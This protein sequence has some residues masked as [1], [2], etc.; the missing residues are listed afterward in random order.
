MYVWQP[1]VPSGIAPAA[2]KMKIWIH[3]ESDIRSG[4]LSMRIFL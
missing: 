3:G 4:S 2:I 1:N